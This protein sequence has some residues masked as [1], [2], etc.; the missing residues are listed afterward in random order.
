MNVV[1]F[2]MN[3]AEPLAPKTVDDAPL[4]KAAPASAPFPCCTSIS[5][6]NKIANIIC[7]TKINVCIDYLSQIE[8]QISMNFFAFNEAP[9][10][11]APSTPSIDSIS[12]EFILLTLP[13]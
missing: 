8:E 4:P 5:A 13:P 3:V 6:T 12:F 9:P 2:V 7:I 10:T 11:K 1:N